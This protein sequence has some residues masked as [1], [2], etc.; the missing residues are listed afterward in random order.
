MKGKEISNLQIYSAR[1]LVLIAAAVLLTACAAPS[2]EPTALSTTVPSRTSKPSAAAVPPTHTPL[3]TIEATLAP[4]ATYTL[5]PTVTPQ[6]ASGAALTVK[7]GFT[8]IGKENPP[9]PA[10]YPLNAGWMLMAD[11]DHYA[12]SHYETEDHSRALIFL[13]RFL[14]HDTQGHAYFL[15]VDAV[16]I[17]GIPA[18][19]RLISDCH[20]DDV[21]RDDII[22]LGADDPAEFGKVI[23]IRAWQVGLP[24]ERLVEVDPASIDCRF[25]L[26]GFAPAGLY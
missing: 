17:T 21:I 16:E 15:I 20:I 18:G 1:L 19:Q 7:V 12:V 14:R 10:G 3:P 25:E 11:Q 9:E 22:L 6:D 8:Y 4:Q 23:A 2:A 24:N 26:M 13:E 5:W